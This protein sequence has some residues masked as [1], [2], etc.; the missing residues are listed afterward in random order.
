MYFDI[1][2]VIGIC[3]TQT[4]FSSLNSE[5][6]RIGLFEWSGVGDS[7][8]IR[9]C[10]WRVRTLEMLEIPCSLVKS[11]SVWIW[12]LGAEKRRFNSDTGAFARTLV[13][14]HILLLFSINI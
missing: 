4:N 11:T 3:M 6:L 7:G 5:V 1:L 13:F 8:S 14:S 2:Q 10:K 9:C 12:Q